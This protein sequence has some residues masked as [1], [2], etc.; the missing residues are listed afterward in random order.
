MPS[1]ALP[2]CQKDI[3]HKMRTFVILCFCNILPIW[4]S[5]LIYKFPTPVITAPSVFIFSAFPAKIAIITYT[6]GEAKDISHLK[7]LHDIFFLVA[8]IFSMQYINN[9]HHTLT[10]F[11]IYTLKY[12][13]GTLKL[14]S[15]YVDQQRYRFIRNAEE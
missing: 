1:P 6:F 2:C 9:N 15:L 8:K 3:S 5:G 4:G 13:F 14:V 7:I 10:N 11:Q 12:I